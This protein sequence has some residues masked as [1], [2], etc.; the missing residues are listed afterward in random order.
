MKK[1]IFY[2]PNEPV[3][4][5]FLICDLYVRY[6]T[7][8]HFFVYLILSKPL[9]I[10]KSSIRSRSLLVSSDISPTSSCSLLLIYRPRKD[11]RL[12]WPSWLTCSGRFTHIRG[13][14]IS[15]RDRTQTKVY[16]HLFKNL[17]IGW[18]CT[19]SAN[20]HL[21]CYGKIVDLSRQGVFSR[22]WPCSQLTSKALW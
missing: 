8:W 19:W 21:L 11:K 20:E 17:F 4:Y 6:L 18:P 14:C 16:A 22:V 1:N 2:Y 7:W 12:S 3:V 15:N 5:K 13:L 10:L 9:K